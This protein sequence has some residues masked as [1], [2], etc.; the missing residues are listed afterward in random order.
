VVIMTKPDRE[1]IQ[2]R[3]ILGDFVRKRRK[4]LRLSSQEVGRELG[5]SHQAI[6][7]KERGEIGV[8]HKEL[9]KLAQI[10]AI[11]VGI[12]QQKWRAR[13]HAQG[14]R[15]IPVINKAS[16]GEVVDFTEF[17]P[18]SAFGYE[19]V[20][21]DSQT[22]ADNLFAVQ[23]VGHSM[24]PRLFEG[25]IVIFRSVPID[26]DQMP[27]PDTVVFIRLSQEAKRPG[28][29]VCRWVPQEGGTYLLKKDNPAFK[30]LV[31]ARE[32]VEQFAMFV[33]RRTTRA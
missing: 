8:D 10:L 15:G 26:S 1:E 4:E 11:D 31:V 3:R 25:D 5:L 29:M 18:T 22:Q 24:E 20:E 30:S 32:H 2:R 27:R 7:G 33:Q 23:I 12:L 6:T 28:G 13:P 14:D 9:P 19:Y 21:R 16:A 17:G